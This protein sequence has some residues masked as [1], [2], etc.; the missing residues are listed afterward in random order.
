MMRRTLLL[1]AGIW[2]LFFAPEQI[3]AVADYVAVHAGK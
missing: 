3:A 2:L 1:E